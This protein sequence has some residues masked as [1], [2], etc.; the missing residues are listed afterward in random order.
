MTNLIVLC[1]S[2]I[3][4]LYLIHFMNPSGITD[5][6]TSSV[7]Y[8]HLKI[9]KNSW[10][11][12]NALVL[13]LITKNLLSLFSEGTGIESRFRKLFPMGNRNEGCQIGIFYHLCNILTNSLGGLPEWN[14]EGKKGINLIYI[15]HDMSSHGC[16]LWN[17]SPYIFL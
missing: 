5:F 12:Y 1:S 3:I 15:K 13:S 6:Y 8:I 7:C 17:K 10:I 11:Q 14:M 9:R 2:S 4:Q 16:K